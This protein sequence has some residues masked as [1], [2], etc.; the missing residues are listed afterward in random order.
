MRV[1][2]DSRKLSLAKLQ[3]GFPEAFAGLPLCMSLQAAMAWK[4]ER[5]HIIRMQAC[6]HLHV[7]H[8]SIM[9]RIYTATKF[10]D[11]IVYIICTWV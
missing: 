5:Q 9:L 6:T 4:S 2:I 7:L 1:I 3:T 11:A 8:P 10:V